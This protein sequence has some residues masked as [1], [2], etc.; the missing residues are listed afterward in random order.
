MILLTYQSDLFKKS[1]DHAKKRSRYWH[2]VCSNIELYQRNKRNRSEVSIGQTPQRNKQY[3]KEDVNKCPAFFKFYPQD[4]SFEASGHSCS[5]NFIN[6]P[7]ILTDKICEYLRVNLANAKS[8]KAVKQ[9]ANQFV[10]FSRHLVQLIPNIS[11]PTSLQKALSKHIGNQIQRISKSMISGD[12]NDAV[13]YLNSRSQVKRTE[14]LTNTD[15]N[16]QIGRKSL[17]WAMKDAIEMLKIY[18]ERDYVLTFGFDVTHNVLSKQKSAQSYLMTLMF[19]NIDTGKFSILLQALIEGEDATSIGKCLSWFETEIISLKEYQNKIFLIDDS[20]AER[21]AIQQV[22]PQR[23]TFVCIWHTIQ[24]ISK[25]LDPRSLSRINFAKLLQLATDPQMQKWKEIHHLAVKSMMTIKL[26][27][28]EGYISQV[29]KLLEEVPEWWNPLTNHYLEDER[30]WWATYKTRGAALSLS[31]RYAQE[32]STV[33]YASMQNIS[34]SANERYHS[35]LK[36]GRSLEKNDMLQSVRTALDVTLEWNSKHHTSLHFL[37]FATVSMSC[38]LSRAYQPIFA[39]YPKVVHQRIKDEIYAYDKIKKVANKLE[40]ISEQPDA[41]KRAEIYSA[42]Q[43]LKRWA[44]H[45][46]PL[47]PIVEHTCKRMTPFGEACRH[48]FFYIDSQPTEMAKQSMINDDESSLHQFLEGCRRKAMASKTISIE[49][50][51]PQAEIPVL[52]PTVSVFADSTPSPP[53]P[54]IQKQILIRSST[55]SFE[56]SLGRPLTPTVSPIATVS[57]AARKRGVGML[58]GP[59]PSTL[60]KIR[61]TYHRPANENP[62]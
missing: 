35:L 4:E 12:I 33:K 49:A 19:K 44:E 41:Q 54:T 2:Y 40:T 24:T 51:S 25:H 45:L 42:V 59:S 47:S 38:P 17:A 21:S 32:N 11:S 13:E 5:K 56:P 20:H 16:M 10:L 30:Q 26:E 39:T 61:I 6:F 58:G 28:H 31:H 29:T 62:Q 48:L 15:D 50:I 9:A 43:S 3:K 1:T 8:T 55:Q 46:P 23:T 18:I 36:N 27:K 14:I 7:Q 60:P 22:W 34:T 53:P 37:Y 52:A 57:S